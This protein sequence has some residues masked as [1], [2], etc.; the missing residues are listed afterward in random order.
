MSDHTQE[1]PG[2]GNNWKNSFL[3]LRTIFLQTSC[4]KRSFRGQFSQMFPPGS[5][6]PTGCAVSH[7]EWG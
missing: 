6:S 1:D 3:L 5:L 2:K 7:M 4:G